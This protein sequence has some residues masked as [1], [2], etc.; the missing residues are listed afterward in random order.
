MSGNSPCTITRVIDRV[1]ERIAASARK[2]ETRAVAIEDNE[3]QF[4]SNTV[5]ELKAEARELRACALQLTGKV[6]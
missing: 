4:S 1:A 5:D 3:A 6:Y 2:L